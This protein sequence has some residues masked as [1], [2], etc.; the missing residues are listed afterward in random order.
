MTHAPEL[1][2]TT[3]HLHR[4]DRTFK[5]WTHL[6]SFR[7]HMHARKAALLFSE[8]DGE[9]YQVFDGRVNDGQGAITGYYL[10]GHKLTRLC[11][12]DFA[13]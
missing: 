1:L 5:E 13:H 8:A 4:W 2:D 10:H 3:V 6:G 9:L 11:P 12:V 7:L